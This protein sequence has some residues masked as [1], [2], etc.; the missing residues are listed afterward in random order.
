MGT[1]ILYHAEKHVDG[2]WSILTDESGDREFFY[3]GAERNYELYEILCGTVEPET[4]LTSRGF[5]PIAPLRGVPDDYPPLPDNRNDDGHS[6]LLLKE[7]ID[8]PW[9]EKQRHWEGFANAE[10][11]RLFLEGGRFRFS[12]TKPRHPYSPVPFPKPEWRVVS[13]DE[14]FD[15]ICG[16]EPVPDNVF[17]PIEFDRTYYSSAPYI[18]L[19]T[20]PMLL[21]HG[22]PEQ[23]RILFWFSC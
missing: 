18:R 19:N 2:K 6:W 8:F 15:L 4:G 9:E 12:P 20:I 1:D 23:I 11:F 22:T 7:L 17:T 21:E 5:E 14:M 13:N 3:F 16:W 10:N